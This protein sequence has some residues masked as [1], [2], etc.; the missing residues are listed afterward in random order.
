MVGRGEPIL[1]QDTRAQVDQREPRQLDYLQHKRSGSDLLY[2]NA[3]AVWSMIFPGEERASG[4]LL[5]SA[6][7]SK[8]N[9]RG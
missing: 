7:I 6:L 4:P 1:E 3:E 5:M 9:S 8:R 2:A